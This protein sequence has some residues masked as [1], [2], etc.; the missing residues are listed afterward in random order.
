MYPHLAG[1]AAMLPTVHR[2]DPLSAPA[3]V[4]RSSGCFLLQLAP[5]R[6]KAAA[7]PSRVPAP[8]LFI[9]HC[10]TKRRLSV[11]HAR[12][13]WLLYKM[14]LWNCGVSSIYEHI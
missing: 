13:V 3:C 8:S 14:T 11:N 12:R 4:C 7:S 1:L 6:A 9:C 5:L 10:R 2:S